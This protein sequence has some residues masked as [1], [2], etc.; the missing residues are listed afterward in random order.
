MVKKTKEPWMTAEQM[1]CLY[2]EAK[3]KSEQLKILAELN[4]VSVGDICVAI[5]IKF[6]PKFRVTKAMKAYGWT[7]AQVREAY[8]LRC[9]GW[10]CREIGAAIGHSYDAVNALCNAQ[11]DDQVILPDGEPPEKDKAYCLRKIHNKAQIDTICRMHTEGRTYREIADALGYS[12]NQVYNT[13]VKHVYGLRERVMP[14]AVAKKE[15]ASGG[16]TP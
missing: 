7:M 10:S 12:Y 3:D 2:N 1:L 5:G 14:R 9:F 8:R 11:I 16:Q 6:E 13:V 15:A 4:E